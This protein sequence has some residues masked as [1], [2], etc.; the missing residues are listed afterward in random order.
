MTITKD[1]IKKALEEKKVNKLFDAIKTD[2]DIKALSNIEAMKSRVAAKLFNENAFYNMVG[3]HHAAKTEVDTPEEYDI[4]SW[5][6]DSLTEE[7]IEALMQ[8]EEEIEEE[9]DLQEKRARAP[10]ISDKNWS[11]FKGSRNKNGPWKW[12]VEVEGEGHTQVTAKSRDM[13]V[14][15]AF[16]K[17]KLN[18]SFIRDKKVSAKKLDES[19]ENLS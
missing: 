6:I 7:E 12:R 8:E 16:T 2:L 11:E 4:E 1:I 17:L 5:D 13:A 3:H 10:R 14:K 15:K 19:N 9:E 18:K